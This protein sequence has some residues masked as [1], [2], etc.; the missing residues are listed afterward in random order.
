MGCN[1]QKNNATQP[2][3]TTDQ[4]MV[5]STNPNNVQPYTVVNA[6]VDTVKAAIGVKKDV[7]ASPGLTLARTQICEACDKRFL[8]NCKECGCII[9]AKVKFTE[10]SCPL[11]KW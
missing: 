6:A 10:S 3:I 1:C 8:R 9:D 4:P 11:N 7:F 2:T 5:Q